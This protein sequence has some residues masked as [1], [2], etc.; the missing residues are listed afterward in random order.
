MFS[1]LR[2]GSLLYI[3]DKSVPSLKIGQ[4]VSVSSPLNQFGA[5]GMTQSTVDITVKVEDKN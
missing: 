1:A 2:Q 4:V 3:L 5:Y